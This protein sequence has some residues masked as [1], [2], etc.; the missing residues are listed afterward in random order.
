MSAYSAGDAYHAGDVEWVTLAEAAGL[1][2]P[3]HKE[4]E[5]IVL[6]LAEHPAVHHTWIRQGDEPTARSDKGVKCVYNALFIRAMHPTC[7]GPSDR[8]IGPQL[9]L[10]QKFGEATA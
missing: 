6:Q 9:R 1:K 4:T 5:V 3:T 10:S 8:N 7:L 2:W